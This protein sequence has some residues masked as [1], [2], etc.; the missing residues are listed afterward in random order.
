M[1][2]WACGCGVKLVGG[3]GVEVLGV[4]WWCWYRVGARCFPWRME[5]RRP[6]CK[7]P[8]PP[9]FESD[10]QTKRRLGGAGGGRWWGWRRVCVFLTLDRRRREREG[11]RPSGS[12][13]ATALGGIA[14]PGHDHGGEQS[15]VA[16]VVVELVRVSWAKGWGGSGGGTGLGKGM[17]KGRFQRHTPHTQPRKPDIGNHFWRLRYRS[18][19]RADFVGTRQTLPP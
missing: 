13:I 9:V 10:K 16:G 1:H 14:A 18:M 6:G 7:R 8:A 15:F 11:A 17:D 4:R 12:E 5:D 3:G 2:G 19:H